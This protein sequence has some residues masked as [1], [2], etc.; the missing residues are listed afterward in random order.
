MLM[1]LITTQQEMQIHFQT[2]IKNWYVSY[3]L[4]LQSLCCWC[5]YTFEMLFIVT[6]SAI[7]KLS[8]G[9]PNVITGNVHIGYRRPD[10]ICGGRH[11]VL[12]LC[13]LSFTFPREHYLSGR[14]W[15]CRSLSLWVKCSQLW[16]CR[17][18]VIARIDSLQSFPLAVENWV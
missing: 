1:A 9:K 17:R 5:L 10:S 4:K 7:E 18:E 3:H 13:F 12:P 6:F 15:Q 8:H 14:Y 11:T 2:R 16:Q